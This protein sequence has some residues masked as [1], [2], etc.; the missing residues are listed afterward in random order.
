MGD[1][2]EPALG[3]QL[4]PPLGHQARVVR[5][6]RQGVPGH[7]RGAGHLQ[8]EPRGQPFP[9]PGHIPLLDMPAVFAQVH[10]DDVGA[11]LLGQERRFHRIRD[12]DHPRLAHGGD[13]ID[14]DSKTRHSGTPK[15][16][17]IASA[18]PCASRRISSSDSPSIITRATRLGAGVAHQHPAPA[19]QQVLALGDAFLNLIQL[20]QGTPLPDRHVH[21]HLRQLAHDPAELAQRLSLLDH[22]GQH[23]QRRETAVAGGVVV[24]K[25]QVPRLLAAQVVPA[26]AHTFHHVAVADGGPQ[27]LDAVFAESDV[28]PHVAHHRCHHGAG[29]QP[30]GAF[31]LDGAH[32]QHLVAVHQPA[33]LVDQHRPVGIAVQ[34]HGQVRAVLQK[35]RPGLLGVHR[36]T[37]QVD[38][39]A[40][41]LHRYR[42]DL[43]PELLSRRPAPPGTPRRWRSPRRSS[44]PPGSDGRGTC[45]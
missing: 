12:V 29:R 20:G 5:L 7:F 6:E 23:L 25:D 14:V 17:W 33:L 13:V 35:R 2:V 8:V 24:Q 36:A 3:G 19:V 30:P 1:H 16:D 28:E 39:G 37:V 18:M 34:A 27:D 31:H 44:G 40:V 45:S 10:R 42:N 38:V 43:G 41:G 32:G 11:G 22:Q 9:Q 4:L 21:H 15:L 26:L